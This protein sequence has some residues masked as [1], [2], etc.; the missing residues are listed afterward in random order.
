M[1]KASDGPDSMEE[2]IAR[3]RPTRIVTVDVEKPLP[4]LHADSHY[5]D[6]WVVLRRDGIPRSASMIDLTVGETGVQNVM[7]GLIA[8]AAES[9]NGVVPKALA[10]S[11]LP[12]ISIVVPTNLKRANDVKLC[13]EEIGRLD[14]PNFEVLLVDNRT[15]IPADDLLP[16]LLTENPWL[17]VIREPKPGISAA[18]NA[19]V[20]HAEADIIAFTDDDVRVDRN[21]LRAIGTRLV[22]DSSLDAITGLI[23]PAELETPAQ[24][25][26]ER[27]YGG[28]GGIRTFEPVTLQSDQRR[29]RIF[30]R[31][32]ILVRNTGGENIRHFPIYG[33]GAYL[34]GANMAFRKSALER[35]GGFDVVLGTGTPARGGDDL[36]VIISLLWAGGRIGYEPAA[37]VYHRHRREL[38]ELLQQMEGNGLGYTAML[39]AL[40]RNDPRHLVGIASQLP[41]AAMRTSV[42]LARRFPRTRSSRISRATTVNSY[43][44]TLMKREFR[45]YLSG[46]RAYFRSRS[47]LR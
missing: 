46:P 27:Y 6:A 43:P 40:V 30:D 26:F 14:Y 5:S 37:Y 29:P 39:T 35:I 11:E 17:R 22:L 31:S 41:A 23:L 33:V 16:E 20:E 32:R 13:L 36:A 7:Q 15:D 12:A 25:W 10:D 21:W 4:S 18:R 45:A 44:S 38:E 2:M 28:F 1:M 9:G 34:A 24:I 8:Q 19:G 47:N 3:A 42:K